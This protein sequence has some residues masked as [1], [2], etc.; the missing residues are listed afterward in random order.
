M[1][2]QRRLPKRGFIPLSSGAAQVRLGDLAKLGA[3]PI[4][5]LALKTAGLVAQDAAKAKVFLAGSIDRAVK[6]Q[7][8]AVTAGARKAI[9]A[10]GGSVEG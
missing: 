4:D 1:P 5:L 8:I 2:L 9:E 6:L 7:G 3:D 10:A